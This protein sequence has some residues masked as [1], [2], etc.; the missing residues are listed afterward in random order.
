MTRW[1]GCRANDVRLGTGKF[2]LISNVPYL[3]GFAEAAHHCDLSPKSGT[4]IH[5][6][7]YVQVMV[8]VAADDC[9]AV[10]RELPALGGLGFI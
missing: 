8:M 4:A 3:P 5:R 9:I 6:P 1:N 10:S 2:L 7:C